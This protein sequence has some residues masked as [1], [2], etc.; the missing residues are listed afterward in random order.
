MTADET[1]RIRPRPARTIIEMTTKIID[2]K[3]L[4]NMT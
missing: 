1:T 4:E 2:R 3:S